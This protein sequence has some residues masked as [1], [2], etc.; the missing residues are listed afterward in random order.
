MDGYTEPELEDP[1]FVLRTKAEEVR[2][3]AASAGT[4]HI[5]ILP[6]YVDDASAQNRLK[7]NYTL[8]RYAE[9]VRTGD[10]RGRSVV[11]RQ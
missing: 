10:V 9:V 4:A 1:P 7:R 6:H 8:A 5:A 11:V 3:T 2:I